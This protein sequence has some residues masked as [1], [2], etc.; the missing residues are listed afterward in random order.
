MGT[1]LL[2]KDGEKLKREQKKTKTCEKIKELF[3][4]SLEKRRVSQTGNFTHEADAIGFCV[5]V[6]KANNI[7]IKGEI[8]E[9]N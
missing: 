6:L 5:C 9:T 1:L 7:I 8:N 2:E 4:V 3:P